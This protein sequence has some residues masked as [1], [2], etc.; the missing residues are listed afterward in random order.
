MFADYV[1]TVCSSLEQLLSGDS[2]AQVEEAAARLHDTIT[3]NGTVFIAG[4]GGSASQA[5]HLA[6]E[7]IG[8]PRLRGRRRTVIA[9]SEGTATLTAL[10][11]DFSFEDVFACQLVAMASPGDVLVILTTSGRSPNI[12]AACKAAR[13]LGLTVIALLGP[14]E[15]SVQGMTDVTICCAGEDAMMVQNVHM[16]LI[17]YLYA[18]VEKRLTGT[19]TA[20]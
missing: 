13:D 14:R 9:L 1:S 16:I 17:H 12:V 15:G 6:A 5:E 20:N 18:E 4:N 7:F 3:R 11:N 8:S 2:A 19:P 10:A